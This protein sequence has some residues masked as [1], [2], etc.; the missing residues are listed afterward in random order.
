MSLRPIDFAVLGM[1][2]LRAMTGYEIKSAYQRGPANFMPIS[3]GQIYP[4]LAKLE[5]QKLI[6]AEARPGIRGS[7]RYSLCSSG[8]AA[9]REW[10]AAHEPVASHRDLL[11]RLFFASRNELPKL[12]PALRDFI[13]QQRAELA[14]YAKTGK[15]LDE[16]HG[17]NARLPI[18]KLVMQYGVL[19]CQSHLRWA[20]QAIDLTQTL[21]KK[22]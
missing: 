20:E 11:L 9:L 2:R 17:D 14:H 8:R 18:W 6:A 7:V 3:Y 16:A 10:I 19:Q 13:G 22:D 4:V 15:W 21:N 1:L 12:Q 5:Q